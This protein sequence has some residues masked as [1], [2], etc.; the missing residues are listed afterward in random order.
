M[1]HCIFRTCISKWLLHIV[2]LYLFM[3]VNPCDS[4]PCT[5]P[6]EQCIF[7]DTDTYQCQCKPGYFKNTNAVCEK[8][9]Y[10]PV[11]GSIVCIHGYCV[12]MACNYTCECDFGYTGKNFFVSILCIILY[13]LCEIGIFMQT[14]LYKKYCK[15]LP[16]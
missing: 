16:W 5:G 15:D 12:E 9:Y 11:D 7:A 3:A 6:N 2:N 1:V 13:I 4:S 14:L 10:C 8:P